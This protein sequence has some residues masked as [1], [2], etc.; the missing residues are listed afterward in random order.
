MQCSSAPARQ[1]VFI[2]YSLRIS[3][4]MTIPVF[5]AH[6]SIHSQHPPKPTSV[7]FT[8]L[9]IN[10]EGA[11]LLQFNSQPPIK[12]DSATNFWKAL[13]SLHYSIIN[14]SN[15][16]PYMFEANLALKYGL[17]TRELMLNYIYTGMMK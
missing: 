6:I 9:F 3:V 5:M 13:L 7:R 4:F 17:Y 1:L 16:T 14:R 12:E 8:E 2:Q 15:R 10:Q 11:C